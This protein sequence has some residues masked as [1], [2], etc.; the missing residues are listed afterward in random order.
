M[1]GC[2]YRK[3]EMSRRS[4]LF[5]VSGVLGQMF[6]VYERPCTAAWMGNGAWLHGDGCSFLTAYW[7]LRWLR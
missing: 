6:S 3:S 4:G 5:V 7:E 2:R 1:L